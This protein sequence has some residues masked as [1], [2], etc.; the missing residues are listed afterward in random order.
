MYM[1]INHGVI[2]QKL[3]TKWK[4]SGYVNNP[5]YIRKELLSLIVC[6]RLFHSNTYFVNIGFHYITKAFYLPCR[7][8]DRPLRTTHCVQNINTNELGF[9]PIIVRVSIIIRFFSQ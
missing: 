8:K 7:V 9:I 5:T 6:C 4:F 1:Y 2:H 3:K